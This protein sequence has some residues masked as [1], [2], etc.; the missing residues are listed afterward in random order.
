MKHDIQI[1]VDVSFMTNLQKA[2]TLVIISLINNVNCGLLGCDCTTT[3][4]TK[5]AIFTTIRTP[6]LTDEQ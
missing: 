5:I 3:Q 2:A 4:K 1:K 6:N